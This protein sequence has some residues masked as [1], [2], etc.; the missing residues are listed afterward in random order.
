MVDVGWPGD[1]VG[2]GGPMPGGGCRVE[3]ALGLIADDLV[4]GGQVLEASLARALVLISNLGSCQDGGAG[5]ADRRGG[6]AGCSSGHATHQMGCGG[7]ALNW[8]RVAASLDFDDFSVANQRAFLALMEA[9]QH[10]GSGGFP[11]EAVLGSVWKNAEAQVE[12]LRHA[13]A[14]PSRLFQ[15]R[16][17]Q[18]VLPV[19]GRGGGRGADGADG[20][21]WVSLDLLETL[22]MLAKGGHEVG[23]RQ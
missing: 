16:P 8:G 5:G 21:A 18:A 3:A 14:A 22:Y 15:F 20:Q 7:R 1:A 11:L 12:F 17:D 9:F 13:V 6:A 23:V 10:G 19:G 2:F 4:S